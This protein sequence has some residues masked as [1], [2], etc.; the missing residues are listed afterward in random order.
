MA[1]LQTLQLHQFRNIQQA[2]LH[3]SPG[4]NLLIGDNAAG[5]TSVIEALWLLASGRSFRSHKPQQLIQF[6]QNQLIVFCEINQHEQTHKLGLQRDAQGITLKLNGE[7]QPSQSVFARHLPIQLLTPESHRLLEEGPK[8]RRQFL[9]WGCFYHHPEF[10]PSWRQ[11]NRALKQRNSSLKDTGSK[12]HACIWN[13][14]MIEAATTINQIRQAYLN[15]ITPFVYDFC[16]R[17]MPELHTQPE[18]QFYPGW[19]A[20][21]ANFSDALNDSL[22]RDAQLGYTQ[23]G[24]HRADIK[25]KINK[26]EPLVGLSRGQQ[27]LFVCALL[28]AQARFLA[29]KT[30]DSVIMLI[31]DLPAELDLTHRINLLALLDELKIQHLV[32]TTAL[33]LIPHLHPAKAFKIDQ[34]VIKPLTIT[35]NLNI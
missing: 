7:K 10:M 3:F 11:F 35:N 20:N 5:K 22:C 8:A 19:P 2:E 18:F 21:K 33:D 15:D 24:C 34:G 26:Q 17:L 1:H 23:Y 27:K 12:Q 16:Q 14:P 13:Q 30:Q 9:D 28:L 29:Q 6:E 4:L 32:T 31:D 25:I